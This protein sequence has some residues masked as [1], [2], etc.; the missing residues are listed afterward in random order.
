MIQ[1]TVPAIQLFGA[2]LMAGIWY[3]ATV[4]FAPLFSPMPA[5]GVT[6]PPV[7][8]S[9]ILFA[10]VVLFVVW[11]GLTDFTGENDE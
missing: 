7:V 5:F 4:E 2:T 10:S 6:I 9:G 11:E 8:L 1:A 3:A